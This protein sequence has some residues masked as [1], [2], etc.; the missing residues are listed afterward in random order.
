MTKPFPEE[1]PR[2]M[3]LPPNTSN[4]HDNAM[5]A[6]LE[7]HSI[8]TLPPTLI[9]FTLLVADRSLRT[10]FEADVAGILIEFGLS[11]PKHLIG[12]SER[13]CPVM[14]RIPV[15]ATVADDIHSLRTWPHRVNT[16][17]RVVGHRIRLAGTGPCELA[18]NDVP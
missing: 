13:H 1:K 17:G 10:R 7:R 4:Q 11:S 16:C 14:P 2:S 5:R 8:W 18:T 12:L 6:E 9:L 3:P 15:D